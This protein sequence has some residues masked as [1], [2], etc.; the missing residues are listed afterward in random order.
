VPVPGVSRP[1]TPTLTDVPSSTTE[2]SRI[3]TPPTVTEAGKG[4]GLEITALLEEI[5]EIVTVSPSP[6]GLPARRWAAR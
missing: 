1:L 5:R 4:A 3:G 2:L 6:H